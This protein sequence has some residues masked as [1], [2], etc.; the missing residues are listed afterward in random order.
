MLKNEE[1]TF[2]ENGPP[3]KESICF[4]KTFLLSENKTKP[5]VFCLT[6]KNSV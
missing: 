2:G 6:A 1:T 5:N 3:L 4:L